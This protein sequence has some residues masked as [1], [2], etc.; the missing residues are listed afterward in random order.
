MSVLPVEKMLSKAAR[1]AVRPVFRSCNFMPVVILRPVPVVLRRKLEVTSVPAPVAGR[2]VCHVDVVGRNGKLAGKQVTELAGHL[3]CACGRWRAEGFD[4]HIGNGG[5]IA[6]KGQAGIVL[7][8]GH[9]P[10]LSFAE[11]FP[12][13][14]ADLCGQRFLLGFAQGDGGFRIDKWHGNILLYI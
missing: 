12:G 10:V 13:N 9:D 7:E 11:T 3:A 8:P 2:K 14:A 1:T 5:R 6:L 4:L